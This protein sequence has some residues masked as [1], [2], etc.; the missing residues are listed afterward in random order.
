LELE[1]VGGESAGL[2][3]TDSDDPF[4]TLDHN[5]IIHARLPLN[6][7]QTGHDREVAQ[8]TDVLT[9]RSRNNVHYRRAPL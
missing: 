9:C 5:L 3:R 7:V 6:L 1:V 8:H 4:H 2:R